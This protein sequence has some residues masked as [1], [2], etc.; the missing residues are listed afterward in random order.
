[1]SGG[2]AWW[3]YRTTGTNILA[4]LGETPI[5]VNLLVIP[6]PKQSGESVVLVANGKIVS[7]R[8]V[9]VAT[10]V[11]G[12]II[13]LN[14]EQGDIVTEGQ[15][16]ARVEDV[17]YRAQRDEAAATVARN[18]HSIA[19]ARAEHAR[20][21][22]AAQQSQ[23]E[24]DFEKYNFGRLERLEGTSDASEWEF[25]NAKNRYEAAAAALEVA[26]A[27]VQSSA[28]SIQVSEADL[29]SSRATLRLLE[30]R[31]DDCAIRAP[32][33][34]VVLERNAHVGDFLAFEGGR[35][36][37]ANA[38]LVAIAD[39][40]LLR[41]EID[42]SERDVHRLRAGQAARVTP[43]AAKSHEYDGKVMWVDPVGDYAKAT[44]GV[45]VR[46]LEPGPDLRVEGSAKVEFLAADEPTE[47]GV[48]K[49]AAP[50]QGAPGSVWL[51]KKAVKLTP[52]S[53]AAEVFTVSNSRAV[54]HPV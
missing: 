42:I 1:M 33:S 10:K 54:A 41:V 21:Q 11:S 23:A 44:V 8:R 43:D 22:A 6:G 18:E 15:V 40:S 47:G 26:K 48:R 3:Y 16:L 27:V 5:D 51:P 2:A 13:E 35:G 14:V 19:R 52:G 12:Q 29:D 28:T 36:A 49:P 20:A 37:Q 46:V 39:M 9:N 24:F 7:D 34:G 45:K 32:I 25:I 38:Q 50:G 31:L 53:E 4:A 17:I 30:K